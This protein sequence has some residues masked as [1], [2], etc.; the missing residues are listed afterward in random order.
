MIFYDL[1][2]LNV[3]LG[4]PQDARDAFMEFLSITRGMLTLPIK[5]ARSKSEV[6]LRDLSVQDS[7]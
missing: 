1:G 3:E 4:H 6:A 7:R 5:Q 2:L